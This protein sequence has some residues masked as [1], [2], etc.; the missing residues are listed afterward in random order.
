MQKVV[1]VSIGGM[2]F[3]LEQEAHVMMLDYL[4]RLGRHYGK[5][6]NS[7]EILSEIESR[8]AELLTDRGYVDMI[9]T[10][11]AV[12][13]V[14]DTLGRPEDLDGE[15]DPASSGKS[16]NRK[17]FRD[18][19]NKI[20]GGVCGGLGAYTGIDPVIF[21][22]IFAAWVFVFMWAW[23]FF[24]RN[25]L[26]LPMFGIILYAVLWILMPEPRTVEERYSMKGGSVSIK[27]IQKTITK[28]AG[29]AGRRL[30][31][32]VRDGVRNSRRF[33]KALG[34]CLEVVAG[35]VLFLAG[36][37]GSMGSVLS[38]LGVGAWNIFSP[39]SMS[40]LLSTVTDA[41]V[42]VFTLLIV[43]LCLVVTIPFVGMLYGGILLLFRLKA[44]RWR[45][46][47]VMF[48]VW[49][50]SL[51]GLVFASIWSF[52]GTGY[53]NRYRTDSLVVGD[54]LYVEFAGCDRWA[55]E[56]VFVEGGRTRYRLM[57]AGE[58]GDERF[59]AVYPELSLFRTDDS[60]DAVLRTSSDW[61]TGN[62]TLES[63]QDVDMQRFWSY[64]G[65]TLRFEPVI[66]FADMHVR[67]VGRQASL[68][69]G[70]GTVV[71]VEKP[72]PHQFDRSFDFCSNRF[73]HL[74]SEL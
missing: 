70:P 25:L 33:W 42:W 18:P 74:L 41:P 65:R 27:D 20:L 22:I 55:G 31:K 51:I 72:V 50:L 71:I 4:E 19:D 38:V 6:E 60:D 3:T 17:L 40:W 2:A 54:T 52:S 8:I 5:S 9:V 14:I 48:I 67:D 16:G 69:V 36:I 47:A 29:A 26:G 12:Q 7:A 30:E 35:G 61:L 32:E 44:P 63:M 23:F 15:S 11:D 28:E 10:V 37:L 45:P 56:D 62:M 21:R 49:V 64:D 34:R 66:F 13:G 24:S 46:G 43:F 1:K 68:T 59:L 58:T 53:D 57:Y 73:L 39:V